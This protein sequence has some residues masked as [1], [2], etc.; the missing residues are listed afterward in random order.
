M[1]E[2]WKRIVTYIVSIYDFSYQQ[3][4]CRKRMVMVVYKEKHKQEMFIFG[5]FKCLHVWVHF[6]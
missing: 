6:E 5:M 1:K 4:Y 2:S 3:I